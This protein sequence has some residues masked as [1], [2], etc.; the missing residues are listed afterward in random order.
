MGI[1]LR[2]LPA[3]SRWDVD[4]VHRLPPDKRMTNRT[5]VPAPAR[6]GLGPSGLGSVTLVIRHKSLEAKWQESTD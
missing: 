5:S 6:N 4:R 1:R 2:L 3:W